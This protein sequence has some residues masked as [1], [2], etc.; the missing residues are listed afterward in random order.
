METTSYALIAI[1]H[2]ANDLGSRT[3]DRFTSFWRKATLEVPFMRFIG[4]CLCCP[5]RSGHSLEA[6]L[7]E[8][9]LLIVPTY[10]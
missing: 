2:E 1:G 3:G 7:L 6:S 10:S 4:E 8:P 5:F 9:T